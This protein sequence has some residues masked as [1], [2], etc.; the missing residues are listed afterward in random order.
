M[1]KIMGPIY[2]IRASGWLGK[3][4][5]KVRGVV[6]NPYP[7]ALK[8]EGLQISFYYNPLG[9]YYQNRRTWHGIQS[10]ACRMVLPHNPNSGPQQAQRQKMADGVATWQGM[11]AEVK[12]IYQK[13]K[14]PKNIPGY[15]RFLRD[16]LQT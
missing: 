2:G 12:D 1:V 11:S 9:Y 10:T 7:I 3:G 13:R 15:N 8:P 6:K 14:Y 16:Y 4:T 5:Y